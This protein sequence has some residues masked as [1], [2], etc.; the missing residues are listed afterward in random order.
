[1]NTFG[2]RNDIVL[3][4][5]DVVEDASESLI[6]S[7]RL[8]RQAEVIVNE[9]AVVWRVYD[10]FVVLVPLA[11]WHYTA[12]EPWLLGIRKVRTLG[13][14]HAQKRTSLHSQMTHFIN[15]AGAEDIGQLRLHLFPGDL[16]RVLLLL[17]YSQAFLALRLR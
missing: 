12:A 11:N 6:C 8:Y 10:D 14:S 15:C 9:R 5:A 17:L 7:L 16:V 2:C 4:P 13:T 1:M 3:A